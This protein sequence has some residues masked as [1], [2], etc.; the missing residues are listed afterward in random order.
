M[1]V[2]QTR[3]D[4]H[5]LISPQPADGQAHLVRFSETDGRAIMGYVQGNRFKWAVA[6]QQDEAELNEPV[7]QLMTVG[8]AL[9]AAA[10]ILVALIARLSSRLL[11]RPIVE[12]TAA[13]ERMSKGEL[14]TPIACAREDELGQLAQALERLRK[15]MKAAMDRLRG[16]GKPPPPLA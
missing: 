2:S 10:A 12:M 13:A 15:S 14:E 16:G 4:G 5:P 9:L 8:L 3:L 6:I 7:R 1:V 11:I